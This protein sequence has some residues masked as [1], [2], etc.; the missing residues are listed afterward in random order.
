[1]ELFID[2]KDMVHDASGIE[3]PQNYYW[4]CTTYSVKVYY[5]IRELT[6]DEIHEEIRDFV[7]DCDN[8]PTQSLDE[9]DLDLFTKKQRERRDFFLSMF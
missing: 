1:M 8:L 9:I 3:N 2:V 6:V 4:G 7:D 5:P